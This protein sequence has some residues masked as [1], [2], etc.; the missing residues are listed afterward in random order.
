MFIRAML[1]KERIPYCEKTIAGIG[2]DK[3]RCNYE[4]KTSC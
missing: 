2:M 4:R 1:V 3:E